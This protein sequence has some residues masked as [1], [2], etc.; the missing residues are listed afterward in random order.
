MNFS[1]QGHTATLLPN[2]KVLVAGGYNII[3][4]HTIYLTARSCMI[5]PKE[6][7]YLPAR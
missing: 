2:G 3:S 1:R 7:E 6:P 5:P 4:H